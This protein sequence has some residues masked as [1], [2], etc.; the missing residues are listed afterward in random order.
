MD[1]DAKGREFV[2]VKGGRAGK[3][4]AFFTTS[5]NQAPEHAQPGE[6][7]EGGAY[8]LSLKLV[9]DV[10][11]VGFSNAGKSTVISRISAARLKIADCP[12]TTPVPNVSVAQAKGGRS[13]VVA[14]LRRI[15]GGASEDR[16]LGIRF[17]KHVERAGIIAHLIDLTQLTEQSEESD[18]EVLFEMI[19]GGLKNSLRELLLASR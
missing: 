19:K 14:D 1:L 5:A 13:F 4:N 2:L 3:G 7:S 18:L 12:F 15:I 9:A 8:Q 11:L 10:G 6:E 16:G 17:L